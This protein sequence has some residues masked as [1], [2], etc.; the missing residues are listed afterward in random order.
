MIGCGYRLGLVMD[1][2]IFLVLFALCFGTGAALVWL[3]LR[4]G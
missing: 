4:F 1:K 3:M 2:L